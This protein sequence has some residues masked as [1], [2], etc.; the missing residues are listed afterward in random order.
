M[1][2]FK[3]I[4]LFTSLIITL[5]LQAQQVRLERYNTIPDEYDLVFIDHCKGFA[6]GIATTPTGQY[7]GQITPE[8]SPYG[9]GAYYTDRDGVIT[10]QFRDAN[11]LFGIRLGTTTALVGSMTHY[12]C[13]DLTTGDPLYIQRD[14]VR[15]E[16]TPEFIA[17]YK[18]QALNY[19]NGDRYVGETINNQR[20]GLGTYYYTNGNYY[21]GRYRNNRRNGFGAMFKS[22]NSITIN[23]WR[24]DE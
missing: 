18:F 12:T 2:L 1:T 24:D 9:F 19:Q 8:R 11:F 6:G 21:Y 5:T 3:H 20:D 17:R 16:P 7:F 10:G 4:T 22:D 15:Y 13:Y 23:Y 14:T